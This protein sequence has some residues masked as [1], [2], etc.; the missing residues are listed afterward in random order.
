MLA[1]LWLAA[2][3]AWTLHGASVVPVSD[4]DARLRAAELLQ[5]WMNAVKEMKLQ[6]GIALDEEDIHES[7]MI[8]SPYTPI[9]TTQGNPSA[10]RTTCNPDMAALVMDL[11][12]QAGVRQG[13]T[14]GAG[15]SG[16]FPALNLA[17]LAA[18]QTMGVNCI[19]IA[20]V[21]ASTYGANQPELTFP[22]MVY[23]LYD[24][25]LL[26]TAPALVTPG[27]DYDCGAEMKPELREQVLER[28][29][30][31]GAEIMEERNYTK[32]LEQRVS[33]YDSQGAIRC[34]IG[35]GG[36][37]ATMGLEDIDIPCG[38]IRDGTFHKITARS[39][40]LQRYNVQGVPT[41]H[42]L[43]IKELVADYGLTYD[44]ETPLPPGESAVYYETVYPKWA[45]IVGL[46]G[47]A[48]IIAVG[49][50]REKGD[51]DRKTEARS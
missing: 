31:Y 20:S 4:Y 42:L 47:A 3:I 39:G 8:G 24:A 7:G 33:I 10:K 16:S 19:Y 50:R 28:I 1:A 25:G 40:L 17:V 27:G 15:F 46:L 35:V 11:L 37:I 22:D 36:N 41:I 2:G 38:L 21:G 34:F 26:E 18:C 6:D 48:I 51:S 32:N 9:T 29:R 5:S 13:D 49:F 12:E 23:R 45:A 30:G 44:P 14:V 43:N